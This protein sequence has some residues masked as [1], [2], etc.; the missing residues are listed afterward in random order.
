M[1]KKTKEKINQNQYIA[2]IKKMWA[3][4]KYRSLL[5]L[6][7]YFIFFFIVIT[8]LRTAYQDND[9]TNNYFSF[10]KVKAEYNNLTNYSYEF[11]VNEESIIVGNLDNNINNFIYNNKNYTIINDVMYEEDEDSLK[12]VDLT[13]ENL[14]FAMFDKL[15]LDD[16][17]SHISTLNKSGVINENSFELDFE[18]SNTYFLTE[19]EGLVKVNILGN[20]M[21]KIDEV[22]VDLT[23]EKNEEF[24]IK[25]KVSD[26][27]D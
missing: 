5:I 26:K 18:V 4:K 6:I 13:D 16:L 22:V 27:N 3:N 1:F 20:T 24:V 12:K 25:M 14:I 23:S 17:V 7:L 19:E 2:F 11:F 9:T 8:G 15:M 10:D 21:N